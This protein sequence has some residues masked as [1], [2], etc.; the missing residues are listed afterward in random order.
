MAGMAIAA[1]RAN[2][3]RTRGRREQRHE[4]VFE[5]G[6]GDAYDRYAAEV[7]GFFPKLRRIFG[8]ES[9]GGYGQ[10][11]AGEPLPSRSERRIVYGARPPDGIPLD[12]F[13][14]P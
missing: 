8:Q 4:D 1:A 3:V 13:R 12:R 5:C 2:R 11:L 9:M 7:S 10:S 6:V 14:M